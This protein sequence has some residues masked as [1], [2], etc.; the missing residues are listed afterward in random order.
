MIRIDNVETDPA[1]SDITLYQMS[2][3]DRLTGAW[4]NL[5]EPN[6]QGVR[7]GFPL[8]GAFDHNLDY[9]PDAPGFSLTCVAGVEAKCVR[10]GYKPW[11]E[12]DGGV[13]MVDLYRTCTHMARADYCGDGIGATR[14][15]TRIDLYDVAGINKPETEAVMPF[16]AAWGTHGAICVRHTRLPDVLD[17]ERLIKRCPRLAE[18]VGEACSE[19]AQGALLYNRSAGVSHGVSRGARHR[20]A[21]E[22][23][24]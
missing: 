6:A 8:S 20:T 22:H 10:W 23:P 13:S 7:K 9:H 14:T 18:K 5:C 4:T 21:P 16:E 11:I 17:L 15:G 19:K 24:R 12:R 3:R 2:T 1:D